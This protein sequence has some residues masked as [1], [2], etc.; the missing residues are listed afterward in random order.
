MNKQYTSNSLHECDIDFE[1][2]PVPKPGGD[3]TP[4]GNLEVWNY[5]DKFYMW[6]DDLH[7]K[8][9]VN[10]CPICGEKAPLQFGVI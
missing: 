10:F 2:Q 3:Q 9:R 5:D 6:S 7:I 1:R 4:N 8:E